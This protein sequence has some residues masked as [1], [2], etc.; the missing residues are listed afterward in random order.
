M[1]DTRGKVGPVKGETAPSPAF[2]EARVLE[3]LQ[4]LVGN[5]PIGSASLCALPE[6]PEWSC[7]YYEVKP[8]NDKAARLIVGVVLDDMHLTIG[9][10]ERELIGFGRGGT[11]ISG[12]S[13]REEFRWIWDAVVN[14]GF[15]QRQTLDSKG[16]VIGGASRISV[17]G[18]DWDFRGGKRAE[19]LFSRPRYRTVAYQPWS[20]ISR[21]ISAPHCSV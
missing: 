15:L 2:N 1:D 12:A 19:T 11:P 20:Q 14:G 6:N 10:V 9:E 18:R 4:R 21:P 13:W 7:R 3:E 17:N 5:L 16:R 8:S